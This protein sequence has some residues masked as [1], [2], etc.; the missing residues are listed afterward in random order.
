M[1]TST[2]MDYLQLVKSLIDLG[3]VQEK[4]KSMKNYTR[5]VSMHG[6]AER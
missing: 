6:I 2:Y 5:P 3:I 1:D 4:L